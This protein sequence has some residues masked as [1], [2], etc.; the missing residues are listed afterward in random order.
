MANSAIGG[1]RYAGYAG[2]D[3]G[4]SWLGHVT[5]NTAPSGR[6]PICGKHLG[7]GGQLGAT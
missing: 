6:K 7:S 1:F 4:S 5:P 2:V 3:G